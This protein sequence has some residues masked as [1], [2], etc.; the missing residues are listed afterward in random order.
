[1]LAGHTVWLRWTP[2]ATGGVFV[3]SCG[4]QGAMYSAVEAYKGPAGATHAQLQEV[5]PDTL[6]KFPTCDFGSLRFMATAGT[7]YY[8]VADHTAGTAADPGQIEIDQETT[9]PTTSFVHAP[10]S[11]GPQ[12][13]FKVASAAKEPRWQC[14]LDAPGPVEDCGKDGQIL[15]SK[16]GHGQHTLS[17]RATDWYGNVEASWKTRTFT[18]DAKGPETTL[19]SPAPDP[20]ATS[21]QFAFAGDEAGVSFQCTKDGGKPFP[22]SS[23][24]TWQTVWDGPREFTVAAVDGWGN[25]DPT[26]AKVQWTATSPAPPILPPRTTPPVSPSTHQ[27]V[28]TTATTPTANTTTGA[29]SPAPCPVIVPEVAP[30]RA[31]LATGWRVRVGACRTTMTVRLGRRALTSREVAPNRTVRLRAGRKAAAALRRAPRGARLTVV[32]RSTDARGAV[33]RSVRRPKLG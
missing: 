31:L 30:R 8:F 16:L 6:W 26:P 17:V 10:T 15:L 4:P 22:C 7:T 28:T 3:R 25:V 27:A 33:H 21:A 32:L 18:V 19:T 29:S 14:V 24:Y 13:L 2:Q 11:T 9:K 23:P 20:V 1:V 5:V 12:A